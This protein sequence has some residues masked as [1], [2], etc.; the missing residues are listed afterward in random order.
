MKSIVAA[1]AAAAVL[2]G[3]AAAQDKK[4][5]KKDD[6]KVDAAKLLGRWELTRS[7]L[8]P[9]PK[10]AIVEFTKDNK[11]TVAVTAGNGKED[12]YTGTYKVNGDKLTV[13]L[14]IPGET[15]QEDTDT[16]QTLTDEKLLLID[17]D[18]K[19][20]EFAKKK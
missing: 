4:D 12:K 15:D 10:S 9:R 1:V 17:K 19:E 13:K 14:T 20:T 6:K 3:V 5:P 8:D 2:I 18:K 11:V 7:T 16:I